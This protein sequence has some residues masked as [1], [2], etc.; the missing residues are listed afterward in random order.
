MRKH[1]GKQRPEFINKLIS[2]N[3]KGKIF[4]NGNAQNVVGNVNHQKNSYV[5]NDYLREF[6]LL[7]K[8]RRYPLKKVHRS[9]KM[10]AVLTP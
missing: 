1:V 10:G 5:N 6:S 8:S 4:K 7:L 3:G 2:S 9:I